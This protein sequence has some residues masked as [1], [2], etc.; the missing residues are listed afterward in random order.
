M[1]CTDANDPSAD[2]PSTAS[3][4][5]AARAQ[6]ALPALEPAR[7][8][9]A[10]VGGERSVW[11]GG[12]PNPTGLWAVCVIT[13][14]IDPERDAW[15]FEGGIF[16]EA[17]SCTPRRDEFGIHFDDCAPVVPGLEV[18]ATLMGDNTESPSIRVRTRDGETVL[19]RPW[20]R[21]EPAASSNVSVL[22]QHVGATPG[23]GD[24]W[25]D[26]GVVYAA[27]RVGFVE[28]LDATSG[29][30][31][32]MLD[33]RVG[34]QAQA[35]PWILDLK[36]R[37]GLLYLATVARGVLIF[38]VRDPARPSFLGQYYVPHG[39]SDVAFSNV[40]NIFLAP[41]RPL[42]FAINH[43]YAKTD[44]RVIDVSDPAAPREAGRFQV[45]VGQ[46]IF[47]GVHNV[48]VIERGGRQFAFLKA[49]L[50]GLYI[51]DVTDPA[52]LEIVS[53]IKWDRVFSHSGWPFVMDGR[54]YY[55]HNDEGVDQGMTVLDLSD[56]RKPRIVSHFQTRRGTSPHEVQVVD[57]IAYLA[58]YVDG[59]R[60]VDLRDPVRP[61][62][63]AHF[64]T[65]PAA[66]ERDVL[67][68]AW[69]LQVVDGRVYLAD[70]ARGV[71]SFAV[72]VP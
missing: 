40:H 25:V 60:V 32:G 37:D 34:Q 17:Q 6:P 21:D 11:V 23:Q 52:K 31:L 68:G 70:F 46:D 29:K 58:Y 47:E 53:S 63:V 4:Q 67:Q 59:L 57:G 16:G 61:R 2:E 15:R 43:S 26:G 30:L 35:T 39:G 42:V 22:W 56:L 7:P 33:T 64:D 72:D 71:Y 36:V 51:L 66:E 19:T 49:M 1:A 62:E 12:A 41:G 9:G 54:L 18:T 69:G 5:P 48:F 20:L 8:A 28:M 27:A 3:N 65:V 10:I 45:P 13:P 24:L 44:L 14:G 50:S 38:D 55:A